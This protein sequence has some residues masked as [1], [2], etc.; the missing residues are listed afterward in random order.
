MMQDD[1]SARAIGTWCEV[2][3][4]PGLIFSSVS[5]VAVEGG[6]GLA[7]MS[8]SSSELQHD[9]SVITNEFGCGVGARTVCFG[10]AIALMTP[11]GRAN[12]D[13]FLFISNKK[14][15]EHSSCFASFRPGMTHECVEC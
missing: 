2:V 13:A 10:A 8:S 1:P 3:S 9:T 14:E 15:Q 5:T 7:K 12:R 4:R 6:G 11:F